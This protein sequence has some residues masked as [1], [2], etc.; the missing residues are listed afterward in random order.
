MEC[1]LLKELEKEVISKE[2]AEKVLEI[3]RRE[4]KFLVKHNILITPSNYEKFFKIFCYLAEKGKDISD[5]EVFSLYENEVENSVNLP[6]GYALEIE[7]RKVLAENLERIA[8]AIDQKLQ[9]AIITINNHQVNIDTQTNNI[10]KEAKEADV[11]DKFRKIL[12]ELSVLRNQ[13]NSLISKLEEYHREII[14]LNTELKIAKQEANM[15][16][17]TGLH[18]RRSFERA[19]S[20][21]I[22]DFYEMKYYFSFIL[23]DI[24]DFKKINDKY[25]H[26]VGDIVLREVAYVFKAFL[27]ANTIIARTGGEEFGIVLPGTTLEDALSVAERIRNILEN[28]EINLGNNNVIKITA[29]F[30]VTQIKEGDDINSVYSRADKALY[31]AK[32]NGKNRVEHF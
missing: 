32:N 12:E 30:G 8:T 10:I 2:T 16:F 3:A 23:V 25:G 14:N 7:N 9:E 31:K 4:L 24:D 26:T 6:D 27:R 22:R 29:S 20:D 21:L 28:R 1:K 15:D 19:L 17:L 5:T 18:N 11:E 13:N